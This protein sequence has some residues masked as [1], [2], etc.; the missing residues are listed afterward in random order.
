[1]LFR[2]ADLTQLEGRFASPVFPGE[3]LVV[4][5]WADGALEVATE[6]GPAITAGRTVFD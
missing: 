3:P 4:R 2:S 6:R 1:M 5:G